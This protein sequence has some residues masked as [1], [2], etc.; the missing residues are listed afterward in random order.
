MELLNEPHFTSHQDFDEDTIDWVN[1][2]MWA[3]MV[4]TKV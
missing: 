2:T 1:D 4:I 3:V